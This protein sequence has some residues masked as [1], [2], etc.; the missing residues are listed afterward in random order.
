MREI[1]ATVV[2][3]SPLRWLVA[4]GD[5]GALNDYAF[6]FLKFNS[7]TGFLTI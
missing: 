7:N 4:R 3:N 1:S 2:L 6:L 5:S